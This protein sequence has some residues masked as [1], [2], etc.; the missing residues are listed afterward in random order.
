MTEVLHFVG[1]PGGAVYSCV[2]DIGEDHAPDAWVTCV[3]CR[4]GIERGDMRESGPH[5]FAK[6][7][8][9]QPGWQAAVR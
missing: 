7:C 1:S 8:Y 6:G 5:T 3:G 2:C 4:A 9:F